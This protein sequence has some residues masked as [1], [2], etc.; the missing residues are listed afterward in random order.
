MGGARGRTYP[1]ELSPYLKNWRPPHECAAADTIRFLQAPLVMKFPMA[2]QKRSSAVSSEAEN[3]P[4][5]GRSQGRGCGHEFSAYGRCF[6]GFAPR[7]QSMVH[8]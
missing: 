1:S 3:K 4:A 6:L 8:E 2:G 7:C 5:Q